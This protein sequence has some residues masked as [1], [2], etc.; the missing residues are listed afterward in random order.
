MRHA[1]NL[2]AVPAVAL[3]VVLPLATV[4]VAQ[5]PFPNLTIPSFGGPACAEIG[6][7]IG[8][9]ITIT[10]A[11]TGPANLPGAPI[12]TTCLGETEN[13]CSAIGFYISADSTITT[14]DV[15]LTGGRENLV[16]Q[17]APGAPFN[18]GDTA[19]NFLF[20]GA[21]VTA[22]S[23][24]GNVYLGA[25]VD[26][27]GTVTEQNE[28]D[29]T[30]AVAIQI[31]AAGSG[32]CAQPDLVVSSFTHDPA[33]PTTADGITLTAVIENVGGAA[34]GTSTACID[35]GGETCSNPTTEMLF[36][37]PALAAG[38]SFE[39][40][41]AINLDVAQGYLNNAEADVNNDVAESNEA[42][43]TASDSFTVT[44]GVPAAPVFQVISLPANGTLLGLS[45][46]SLQTPCGLPSVMVTY[47]P[48]PGFLGA[49]SFQYQI[50]DPRTELTSIPAIIDIL[51]ANPPGTGV[52]LTVDFQGTG[53]GD[54][55]FDVGG[56]IVAICNTD[57]TESLG[58]GD[59]VKLQARP[60][61]AATFDTWGGACAIAGGS[62][63]A[64]V[65]LPASGGSLCT[66]KFDP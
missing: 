4:A 33:S 23:P 25:I 56:S 16:Q 20:S 46:C 38:A 43:N 32:G 34:A 7:A 59:I 8:G 48:A 45:G 58:P 41:R 22:G 17:V 29:N 24:T 44:E 63:I 28:G 55:A 11:N 12:G 30:A 6:E 65:T 47:D 64:T 61:G 18:V 62:Q 60:V 40:K 31:V 19:S 53:D 9:Q 3:L 35:V 49:D 26:E 39:V 14:S 57:C 50:F 21:S 54:V 36:A 2:A 15:L 5:G 10:M 42:N 51:V 27:Q 66:A 37:V 52:S 1:K 13:T